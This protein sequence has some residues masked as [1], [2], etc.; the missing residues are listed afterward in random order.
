MNAKIIQKAK[1]VCIL[2]KKI[3]QIKILDDNE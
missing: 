3:A 1:F 2:Y